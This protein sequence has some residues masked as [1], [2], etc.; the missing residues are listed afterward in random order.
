MS[1]EEQLAWE[2]R[3]R[4]RFAAIALLGGVLGIAS[5]IVYQSATSDVP[6]ALLLDSLHSLEQPGPIADAP[7]AK[8]RAFEHAR[9]HP[10]MEIAW[11]VLVALGTLATGL[12]LSFI[13]VCTRARR[14]QPHRLIIRAATIG[15]AFIGVG[16]LWLY[17]LQASIVDGVLDGAGTVA[18]SREAPSSGNVASVFLILGLLGFAIGSVV[19]A[20]N[21]MRAGLLTRTMGILGMF[22]GVSPMLLGIPQPLLPLWTAFLAPLFLGRWMGGQPP[23]WKTG[24]EEP[25]PSAAQVREERMRAR[26]QLAEPDPAV[27]EERVAAKP[28]PASKKRKRK[29][30]G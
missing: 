24:K 4:P 8:L 23:A 5:L 6:E 2:E 15:A 17:F 7:T 30:R 3:Q 12:A 29:R 20:L 25:W 16:I 27:V 21:A 18:E 14:Q 26:G 10:G 22:A 11:R 28:H 1:V 13:G 19:I 9:E